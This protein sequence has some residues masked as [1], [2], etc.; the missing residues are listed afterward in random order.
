MASVPETRLNTN[1]LDIPDLIEW[2]EGM[3]LTPQ[4][5]QQLAARYELLTHFM[6]AQTSPFGWGVIDMKI[7]EA[8]L[9]GGILRIL[10]VEAILPDGLLA[11][12]GSDR[13]VK[14]EFDLQKAE[15]DTAR[16]YLTVPRDAALYN[17]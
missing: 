11:L 4:H 16:I 3:L 15:E 6:F 5:F 17:R 7:D 8:A 13:G 12:G 1:M 9:G 10:N 2:H 14:L